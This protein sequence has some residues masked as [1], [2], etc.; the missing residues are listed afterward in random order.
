MSLKLEVDTF[1]KVEVKTW[2]PN[3]VLICTPTA[4]IEIGIK[5]FCYVVAYVLT[6]TDLIGKNDPRLA[7]V[8]RLKKVKTR[9]GY[10][11]KARRL[12]IK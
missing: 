9:P 3:R 5:D 1:Q 8:S 6:N 11:P 4:D 7:L 10:N 2:D 12:V